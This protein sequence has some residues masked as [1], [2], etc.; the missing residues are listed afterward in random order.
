[1]EK[2]ADDNELLAEIRQFRHSFSVVFIATVD[3]QGRPE[4]SHA[5]F[6]QDDDGNFYIFISQLAPHTRNLREKPLAGILLLENGNDSPNPFALKR[7]QYDC[8]VKFIDRQNKDYS[9]LI[10]RF[11]EHFG[12][13]VDTLNSL[14]DFQLLMLRPVQGKFVRGFAQTYQLTGER[15]Q[16]LSHVKGGTLPAPKESGA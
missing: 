16:R 12:R 15:L 7:L 11:R 5:P 4:A 13:F 1:M 8:E 14:G 10:N 6:I 2:I 9:A 3:G